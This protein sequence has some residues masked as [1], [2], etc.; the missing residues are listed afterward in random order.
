MRKTPAR[1]LLPLFLLSLAAP[2]WPQTQGLKSAAVERVELAPAGGVRSGLGSAP[3]LT[4]GLSAATLTRTLAPSLSP[5]AVSKPQVSASALAP[6]P[7]LPGPAALPPAAVPVPA[8]QAGEAAETT[9]EQVGGKPNRLGRRFDEAK[10]LWAAPQ[11]R[12]T[13]VSVDAYSP[14]V[15]RVS[16]SVESQL[17]AMAATPGNENDPLFPTIARKAQGFLKAIDGH[18]KS[19][20]ID[21]RVSI[22]TSEADGAKPLVD[23]QLRVGVYPV[24]GDPLHWGHLLIG[25]QAIAELKLDKVVFVMAGDDARKPDMTK[26]AIRHP[27]GRAVLD[28]FGPFFDYS[29]IAVGTEYDGETNIFRVLKLN[30]DQRINAYYMVG[31]DHYKLKNASGGDDTIPKLEKNRLK[32]ELGYD[33]KVHAMSVAFMERETK[34]ATRTSIPSSLEVQFLPEVEFDASSTAVR[35]HGRYALMPYSAYDYVRRHKLGLY[36]IPAE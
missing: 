12:T 19:G 10:S 30:P 4:P 13:D 29:A 14:A 36:G 8:E 35:K 9:L 21:P 32:P 33:A 16:L 11:D 2:A 23:R 27:L 5:Q 28:T 25:L 31:D 3:T 34:A 15:A 26:A 24:A 17:A 6:T 18:I 1:S 22:R 20:A 7:L